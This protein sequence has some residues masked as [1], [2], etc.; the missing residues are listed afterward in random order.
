MRETSR[1]LLGLLLLAAP[2]AGQAQFYYSENPNVGFTNNT[3]TLTITGYYGPDGAVSVPTAIDGWTVTSIGEDAFYGC[4]GVTNVTIPASVSNIGAS[5]FS[6]SGLTGVTIPGNVANI[7]PEAFADCASLASAIL[8]NGVTSIAASAF[9]NCQVLAS[10]T[11]PGSVISIGPFAFSTCESLTNATISEGV[12]SIGDG[13]FYYCTGLT[14]VTIPPSVTTIGDDAFN[15]CW[16]LTGITVDAQNSSYS[17]VD[18]VLY[19]KSATTII[20]APPG[21]LGGSFTIPGSVT[22]I[23]KD[24]FYACGSLTNLTIL[25]SVTSIGDGAFSLCRSLTNVT[26]PSSVTSIGE[27]A[28]NSCAFLTSVSFGGDAPTADSTVFSY[29]GIP[30]VYYLPGTTGWSSTFGGCPTALWRLPYPVMINNGPNFGV[31]SNRFGF[32]ISW[33]TNLS[34]VVEASTNLAGAV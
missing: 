31:Q 26:I 1:T 33:A 34:L 27:Y 10:I 13:A 2:V 20:Q 25:N 21:G 16:R 5:A 22:T 8:A 12:I 15:S 9:S 28:F 6:A 3:I 11:I 29:H 17:S 18:G 4:I 30:T 24:A 19:D 7:G 23:G 14:S 32:T